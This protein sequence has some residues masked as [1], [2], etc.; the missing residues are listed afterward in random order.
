MLYEESRRFATALSRKPALTHSYRTSRY[1]LVN[2]R[3]TF[4][5]HLCITLTNI[6]CSFITG[7][8]FNSVYDKKGDAVTFCLPC[9]Q[10]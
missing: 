7:P 5:Q 2:A 8:C 4:M 10:T 9:R 1:G 3:P 6:I